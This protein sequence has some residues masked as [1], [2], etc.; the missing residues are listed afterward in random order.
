MPEHTILSLGAEN[1]ACF[2][3]FHNG[4]LFTSPVF[5]DLTV[6]DNLNRFERAVREYLGENKIC[7]RYIVCDTH[8]DY[9][10]ASF[11]EKLH[12][13]NEGSVLLRVQHHFAHIAACMEDN[14]LDEEVTGVS[15]DGTGYGTD[16]KSW[17]GE[18]FLCSRKGFRRSYHL[19][20]M[21]QPGGDIAAFEVWRMALAYLYD[22]YGDY[23][24]IPIFPF[25]ERV[26]RK[27]ADLI[28]AMI[29][30]NI[31]CPVTSSMGRLFDAV[32]SL[33]GISDVSRK[34]AEAAI[35]LEK[36]AEEGVSESYGYDLVLDEIDVSAMTGMIVDD[37]RRGTR[38]GVISSKFHNT[39]GNI[40]FDMSLKI[41]GSFGTVKTVVSGGCFQNRYLV[42]YLTEKFRA[43]GMGLYVHRKYAATDENISLGQ[44]V[45][46]A[47]MEPGLSARRHGGGSPEEAVSYAGEYDMK[48]FKG[49]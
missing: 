44:A 40:I 14:G 32:A 16:G 2:S 43:S 46:A 27:K 15:F 33:T 48:G 8:P 42:K 38:P 26:G 47:G 10:S 39:V 5:G 1:K 21:P 13:E 49:A 12:S 6:F 37:L 4:E 19:K 17:G 30:K 20:Y 35:A 25:L 28:H 7:P 31:N 18:F 22:A 41:R 24:S 23:D 9:V 29:D 34:E 45:L 36:E 11:A 3:V